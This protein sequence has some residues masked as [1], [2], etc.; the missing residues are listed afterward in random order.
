MTDVDASASAVNDSSLVEDGCEIADDLNPD[1]AVSPDAGSSP[2]PQ[3]SFSR[4][5]GM[6]A[7]TLISSCMTRQELNLPGRLKL[8]RPL[9]T[10]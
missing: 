6:T 2:S 4:R 1:E 8:W 7:G 10:S 9:P 5:C 3:H